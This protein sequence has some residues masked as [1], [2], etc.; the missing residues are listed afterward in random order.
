MTSFQSNSNEENKS[1]SKFIMDNLDDDKII[2]I[3]KKKP[4]E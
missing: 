1:S 3:R 2:Q 4:E